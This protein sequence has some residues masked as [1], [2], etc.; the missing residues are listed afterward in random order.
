[1]PVN[2]DVKLTQTVLDWN[3]HQTSNAVATVTTEPANATLAFDDSEVSRVVGLGDAVGVMFSAA[4][5]HRSEGAT[6]REAGDGYEKAVEL[7]LHQATWSGRLNECVGKL[8]DGKLT[9]DGAVIK[10]VPLPFQASGVVTLNLEFSNGAVLAAT[11]TSVHLGQKAPPQFV[12]NF[13]C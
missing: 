4:H 3:M 8:A 11:G 9:I 12:D 5:V 7:L 10:R 2:A 1:M 6:G 13:A